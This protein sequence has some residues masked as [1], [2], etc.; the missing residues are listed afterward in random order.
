MPNRILR[1]GILTS[2]RI[3]R[4]GWAEEV[5]YRRLM[6]VV[7]DFG[8]YYATPMLLRAACYPLHLDKVS[9]ADIGKWTRCAE[10]AGLVSVYPAPDGKRYLQVLDFRQQVRAKDSRFPSPD[11]LL[12]ST[13]AADD[14]QLLADAHLDVSVDV[15]V[16]EGDTP[17][18]GKRTKRTA[19]APQTP[20]PADFGI[21]DRV[22]AWAAE[23][24]FDRLDEHLDAFKRKA[25][26]KG[27]TYL[28]WDDAFMEAIRT[29]WAQL[30]VV[31][32]GGPS[33]LAPTGG[34]SRQSK[35]AALAPI[36]SRLS[37]QLRW[38]KGELDA[39]RMTRIAYDKGVECARATLRCAA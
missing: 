20:L 11:G 22:R 5:F 2:E 36:E 8:R 19:K 3:A 37:A 7:D 23:K 25:L 15:S 33:A 4:L 28:S 18:R 27:Y 31:G 16:D 12:H 34:A 13:C 1:E 24:R 35:D 21:S 6:S 32:R 17:A 14:E 10:E 30:R 9:D 38:L 29:D 26:A 39:G